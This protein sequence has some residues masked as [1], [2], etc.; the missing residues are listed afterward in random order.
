MY[1]S[2]HEEGGHNS[3]VF[4]TQFDSTERQKYMSSFRFCSVKS[5]NSF[6]GGLHD[7]C[8]FVM[9]SD[10]IDRYM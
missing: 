2:F 8:K 4:N 3:D 5:V 1:R 7:L 6:K 9:Y 10:I